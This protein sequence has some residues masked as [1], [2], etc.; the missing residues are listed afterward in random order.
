V[1]TD[2]SSRVI[3]ML[4]K[5]TKRSVDALGPGSTDRFL[6]DTELKGFGLKVTPG[7]SKVYVL[8]Y[9]KGGRVRMDGAASSRRWHPT[10][11]VTIGQHGALT[12]EQAREKA[13]VLSAAVTSG[14]DPAALIAAEKSA[15]T[16]TELA[17]RFL[18]EHV[19]T[20][21]KPS[22]AIEYRRML[23]TVICP[24]IGNKR[25]RDVSRADV[26]R[27][28]HAH[29]ETPYAANRALAILS[30]MFTLAEK[31]GERPD[32]SNPCRHVEKYA[33]LKRERMLSTD[34]FGRLAEALKAPGRPPYVVA[35]V[36]LLIFTGARLSEVLGLRWEWID[37]NAARRACR[38]A[39]PA[40]RRCTCRLPPWPCSPNFRAWQA[41]RSS[42]WA[43]FEVRTW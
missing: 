13:K 5:I 7:G 1:S 42:S 6:W 14:G 31:W 21:T 41:T 18:A 26:S 19:A 15:P 25:A 40:Q 30:K 39:R 29:H 9:R 16:V 32:G 36:K 22:T 23:E 10:K 20:K 38:T 12:P 28:H 33:E 8:Q 34:E 11:R 27:L 3:S 37:L 17:Q 24:A 43:T 2:T 4:A 35:A